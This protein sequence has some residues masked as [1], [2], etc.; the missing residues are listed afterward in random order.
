MKTLSL[1]INVLN[2]SSNN[3][4]NGQAFPRETIY[5]LIIMIMV[6]HWSLVHTNYH[7]YLF[8]KMSVPSWNTLEYQ[9]KL[10]SQPKH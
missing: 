4:S 10:L 7:N 5:K 6:I 8:T 9:P 1:S 3:N 2:H